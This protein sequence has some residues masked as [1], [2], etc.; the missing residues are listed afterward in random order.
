MPASN[1]II[2]YLYMQHGI[3]P[4]SLIQSKKYQKFPVLTALSFGP[5]NQ[6]SSQ[7]FLSPFLDL[8][9]IDLSF[10]VSLVHKHFLF[11]CPVFHL[12]LVFTNLVFV[13]VITAQFYKCTLYYKMYSRWFLEA[14]THELSVACKQTAAITHSH[15][16][17]HL[18]GCLTGK[19]V[20]P[21]GQN[22]PVKYVFLKK[23]MSCD[24]CH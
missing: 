22:I 24:P 16:H 23:A 3:V 17:E 5:F 2:R 15:V 7:Q 18:F 14:V 12:F 1:C 9:Y 4:C 21:V 19:T 20:C 10:S 13:Q 11:E 8:P 6:F